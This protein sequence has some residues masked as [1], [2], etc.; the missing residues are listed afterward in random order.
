MIPKTIIL[1]LSG[2]FDSVTLLYLLRSQGHNV[3]CLLVDYGQRHAQELQ[4]AKLHCHRLGV[5]FTV[6]TIPRLRGSKLTDDGAS[7]VVPFRNGIML[8]LAANLA[9]ASNSDT[10]AI[11]CN[12]DDADMFPDCTQCFIDSMNTAAKSSGVSVEI[13]APFLN[14]HKWAIADTARQLGVP[15]N[16]TWSCYHGGEKPCGQ[17]PACQKLNSAITKQ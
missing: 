13:C 2:G 11:G 10:V 9:A 15:W 1:L 5:L 8:S 4:F 7:Y 16:E 6:I 3:H 17:C 12:A 14:M